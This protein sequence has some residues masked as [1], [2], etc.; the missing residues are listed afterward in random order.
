[1]LNVINEW[2]SAIFLN[3]EILMDA[4]GR[5]DPRQWT[6]MIIPVTRYFINTE[7]YRMKK[8]IN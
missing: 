1:M 6:C 5:R 8:Y 2:V 4:S 7:M 3:Q